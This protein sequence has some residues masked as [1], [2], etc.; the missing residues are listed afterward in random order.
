MSKKEGY[1]VEGLFGTVKHYD[2]KGHKIGESVPSIWGGYNNYDSKGQ[3]IGETRPSFLGY[4]T[5]D[6]KGH[7]TGSSM[8]GFLGTNHYDAKGHRVGTTM[9]GILGSNTYGNGNSAPDIVNQA[10]A[11]AAMRR[12][13]AI[14]GVAIMAAAS[15]DK[16]E[17]RTTGTSYNVQNSSSQREVTQPQAATKQVR[18]RYIITRLPGE[19]SNRYYNCIYKVEVGEYVVVPDC[20][21]SLQ[22]LAYVECTSSASPLP[23]E[24]MQPVLYVV[25]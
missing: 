2:S 11:A 13:E 24:Q 7:K 1:S 22:V 15:S 20:D 16:K 23:I 25:R 4:N 3:K 9:P 19:N 6:N 14:A 18:V 12:D 5:Y 8:Q 17:S 10:S 21:S